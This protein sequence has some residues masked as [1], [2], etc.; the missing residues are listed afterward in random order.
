MRNLFYYT[1]FLLSFMI[2]KTF[3]QTTFEKKVSELSN[4]MEQITNQEKETLKKEIEEVNIQLDKGLITNEKA[5]ERKKQLAEARATIIENKI[6]VVQQELNALIQDKIDG[7]IAEKDSVLIDYGYGKI[8]KKRIY[9]HKSNLRTTTQFVFAAG[10]N[11]IITDGK[12]LEHSDY[13][14]WGSHFYEWGITYNTRIFKNDNL[15]HFKYGWSVM[16]NNLRP[17]DNRYFVKNQEITRLETHPLD[18]KESRLRNV[19]LVFPA[20]LEF[21]FTP[22]KLSKDGTKT[23]FRTHES[24]RFGIGG[25]AGIRIKS[26]QI[27]KYKLDGDNVK[28]KQKGNFNA[29]DFSYGLSAYIGHRATSLYLKYDLN[30]LF[31]DNA[32]KQNNVSLGV[33]FDF[34]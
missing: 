1:V 8:Y 2:S 11:N 25:Y 18:L 27:L 22:K 10:L 20:H 33:R 15:L 19:Y 32:V 34:N 30:T 9:A 4:K 23:H 21:D 28:D 29:S 14:V 6:A 16:Y 5:V 31:K 17:T 3:A 7:K 12:D 26:K 13:R 24:V